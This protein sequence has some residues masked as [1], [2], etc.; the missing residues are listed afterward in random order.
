MGAISV[1]GSTV[2]RLLGYSWRVDEHDDGHE[3]RARELS[4]NII[5]AFWHGR[6]LPL[7]FT[8]RNRSAQILAS[9]HRDGERL[10]RTMRRLGFGQVR[11]SS[12][13]GGARAIFDLVQK[14]KSGYDV[15]ITVDGPR[16]P[17]YVVK[18]GPILIAKRSGAA[19]LPITSASR[20]HKT[21]SSWDAFELPYPFTRVAVRYGRPVVVSPDADAGEMERKRLEL[22]RVLIEITEAS[23]DEIRG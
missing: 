4:P 10:G 17:R 5:Y 9:E 22:E 1:V 16:G 6:L 21:F 23:D 3:T 2:I 12:T 7:S 20:R 13:R 15:G 14:L 19:V 11:G 18:P 8:H